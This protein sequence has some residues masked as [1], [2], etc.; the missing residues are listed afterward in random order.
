MIN[1][2]GEYIRNIAVFLLFTSFVSILIPSGK[3][4]SYINL[5]IGF[6]LIFIVISPIVSMG[7]YT[8][9]EILQE[10][11][12][13]IHS[14][15]SGFLFSE[16]EVEQFRQGIIEESINEAFFIKLQDPLKNI[17]FGLIGLNVT[18]ENNQNIESIRLNVEDL[19]ITENEPSRL[20]RVERISLSQ[21]AETGSEIENENIKAVKELVSSIYNIQKNNIHIVFN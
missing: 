8:I 18:L 14:E 19:N 7:I 1:T 12:L 16:N 9:D 17:G 2:I 15:D 10:V 6:V 21:N 13:E 3:F 4:K 5:I 11:N 20:I